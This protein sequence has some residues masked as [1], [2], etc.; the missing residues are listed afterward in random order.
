MALFIPAWFI[1]SLPLRYSFDKTIAL[2]D[3]QH[4]NMSLPEDQ[5]ILCQRCRTVIT[6]KAAAI[7][8]AGQHAH[9]LINPAGVTYEVV[10]YR[11]A[12]CQ[13]QGPPT[14]E[15]TWFAGFTWQIA[16]CGHCSA[17][18]GWLYTKPESL[19][20][21]GLIKSQLMFGKSG[22]IK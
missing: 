20:F 14:P 12:N 10:L 7:E 6:T 4:I 9:Q 5:P 2:H 3:Q 1:G 19:G 17:H 15:H 13:V 18:L 8:L 16:L 11:E 22:K 21:Y